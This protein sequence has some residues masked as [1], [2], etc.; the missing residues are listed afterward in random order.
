MTSEEIIRANN[1]YDKILSA[2][3][4]VYNTFI[5]Y[6]GE[7]MVDMIYPSFSKILEN[8]N[9][10]DMS[11]SEIFN[12]IIQDIRTFYIIIRFPEVKIEN[13]KGM[14]VNVKDIWIRVPIG[15]YSSCSDLSINNFTCLMSNAFTMTRSVYK[16]SHLKADYMHSHC[17]GLPLINGDVWKKCCLGNG[18]IKRTVAT[19]CSSFDIDIW[20]LFCV[21]IEK[22]VSTE[23]LSG[24][25]YRYMSSMDNNGY[26]KNSD[27]N[28]NNILYNDTFVEFGRNN[29][30]N[31]VLKKM[32]IDF[33]RYFV[34]NTKIP[35]SF[36][37]LSYCLGEDFFNFY[38]SISR[39]FIKWYNNE[40]NPWNTELS[41][42]SMLE[43]GYLTHCVI[44]DNIVYRL[45]PSH[46][47]PFST[48]TLIT[49]FKDRPMFR[50]KDEI[51][52]SSID[53]SCDTD[54]NSCYL[55][56]SNLVNFIITQI[57]KFI[58]ITFK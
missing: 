57:L 14:Y 17:P 51:I 30:E 16:M 11:E 21:E 2:P 31:N 56:N 29:G 12:A 7:D 18:P 8:H 36:S 38:T 23:S 13:E 39:G 37:N 1:V 3:L 44:D 52:K 22:Y 6:F 45:Y 58:K 24:G 55:L 47:Y 33:I 41:F 25:P 32:T 9:L 50:F 42:S 40:N 5:E 48:E 20:K 43:R 15:I 54:D 46:S 19:L 26:Q 27:Q 53:E 34:T 4:E 35:I 49:K 28:L 10:N